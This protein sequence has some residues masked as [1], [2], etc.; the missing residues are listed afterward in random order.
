MLRMGCRA[1]DD[2]W[3]L[4]GCCSRGFGKG[5]LKHLQGLRSKKTR[6]AVWGCSG[7]SSSSSLGKQHDS[8]VRY[9]EDFGSIVKSHAKKHRFHFHEGPNLEGRGVFRSESTV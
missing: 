1:G 4:C 9:Q 2:L 5:P 3:G 8:A 6:L 7:G